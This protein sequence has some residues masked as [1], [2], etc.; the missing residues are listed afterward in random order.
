[1]QKLILYTLLICFVFHTFSQLYIITA[2]IVN[3]DYIAA[4]HCVNRFK[5]KSECEGKCHLTKELKENEE[6]QEQQLPELNKTEF[7]L[8]SVVENFNNPSNLCTELSSQYNI[9]SKALLPTDFIF[10]VF[11]PPQQA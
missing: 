5:E 4:N 11:H 8:F 2:F 7:Q 9:T 3:R 10:S 1:M 6:R